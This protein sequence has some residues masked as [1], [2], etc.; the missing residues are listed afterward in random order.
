MRLLVSVRTAEEVAPALAGGADIVD[1]KDPARGS[2]GP[3]SREM[4]REIAALVPPPTPFSVALGDF[5]EGKFAGDAVRASLAA[6]DGLP[7]R[8]PLYLKLGFAGQ[9]SPAVA[10]VIR[11]AIETGATAAFPPVIV[12]V[13]YADNENAGSP[14]PAA[15]LSAALATGARAFLLD[16]WSKD[17]RGLPFWTDVH[18]LDSLLAPARAAGLLVAI[19][20]SLDLDSLDF[21]RT[22]ADVIGVRG[23]ACRG[24][25][26]GKVD[27]DLV[28]G[29]AQRLRV[30]PH[31]RVGLWQNARTARSLGP[32][33]PPQVVA[34]K[35]CRD[36]PTGA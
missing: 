30:G 27:T 24:G 36:S 29:L 6:L 21:V 34:V 15:V 13:A 19:A 3:V 31:R 25:R 18:R 35:G 4:L 26:G 14:E 9:R 23:A 16:T 2:L 32:P 22:R 33:E 11:A 5:G 10:G 17:G 20:G 8:A 28:R 7:R 1:A 12:P